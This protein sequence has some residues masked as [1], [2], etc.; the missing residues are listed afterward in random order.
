MPPGIILAYL[1]YIM[2]LLISY[3]ILIKYI[4]ISIINREQNLIF[5]FILLDKNTA[6]FI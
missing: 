1:E 4:H 6:I 3:C 2:F 5:Q